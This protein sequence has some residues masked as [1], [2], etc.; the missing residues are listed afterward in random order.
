MWDIFGR[1]FVRAAW[2]L[3]GFRSRIRPI[4]RSFDRREFPP[5]LALRVNV[6]S[7]GTSPGATPGTP[8]RTGKMAEFRIGSGILG[9]SWPAF[10][11]PFG[12]AP[13]TAVKRISRP[14]VFYRALM[15]VS[16][17]T[18]P[19]PHGISPTVSEPTGFSISPI[20]PPQKV[21]TAD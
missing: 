8:P 12:V 11:L 10:C 15:S 9:I 4:A 13:S 6:H 21:Y 20:L 17:G 2:F 19:E 16:R 18:S 1:S 14:R 7:I 5:R 3:G